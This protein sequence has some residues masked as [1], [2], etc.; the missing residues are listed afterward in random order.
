MNSLILNSAIADGLDVIGDRWSLLILR[1]AFYGRSR[2]EEFIQYTGV[3]RSTLTRRLAALVGADILYKR[4]YGNSPKRFEYRFTENGT[5]LLGASL[6]AQQW[7][8][9]WAVK[10]SSAKEGVLYHTACQHA[11][12]PVAICHHCK[13]A[14]SFDDV[15]WLHLD[16]QLDN[17]LDEIRSMHKQRRVRDTGQSKSSV[18]DL[19]GLVGDRWTLLILISVFFGTCRYDDFSRRLNIASGI[20]SERLKAMVSGGIMSRHSY[21]DNPPRYEYRL[22]SKGK[23]IYPFIMVLRQWVVRGL[24]ASATVP[25]LIHTPCNKPLVIDV[26]CGHCKE[27][28]WPQDIRFRA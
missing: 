7:Q 6:L 8:S 13:V 22:T 11:L 4:P 25:A 18:T 23:S 28:P 16:Q 10:P 1:E 21:Q 9:Q 27:K 2:F 14:L 15:S 3:S 26:A 19:V 17:Q 24:P 5:G 20:L 12:P